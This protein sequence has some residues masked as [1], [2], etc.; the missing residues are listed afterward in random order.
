M[1]TRNSGTATYG[2]KKTN[3]ATPKHAAR[4]HAALIIPISG[5]AQA[6]VKDR[7]IEAEDTTY[8]KTISPRLA[9][10]STR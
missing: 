3:K 1:S 4:R 6:S 9:L 10:P 8:T 7:R 5:V 2:F